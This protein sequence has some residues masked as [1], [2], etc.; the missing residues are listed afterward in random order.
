MGMICHYLPNGVTGKSCL[1]DIAQRFLT[2]FNG[3]TGAARNT[4][5]LL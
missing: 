3:A 2:E 4:D 5:R 1:V